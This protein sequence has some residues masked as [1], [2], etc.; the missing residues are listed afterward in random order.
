MVQKPQVAVPT[1]VVSR[2]ESEASD[3]GMSGGLHA[4]LSEPRSRS[5]SPGARGRK[6]RSGKTSVYLEGLD[7]S[8]LS[9]D[10]DELLLEFNWD[11]QRKIDQLRADVKKE[12]SRVE[13]SNVVVNV[14][15]DDRVEQL[16]I[17]LDKAIKECEDMDGLLT[18]YAVELTVWIR[19][20]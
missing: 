12:L 14:E 18:L 10:I 16:S 20:C 8:G 7:K 9:V 6:R 11:G 17:L 15:G 4:P 3:T 13:S 2:P 19:A 1:P 5:K